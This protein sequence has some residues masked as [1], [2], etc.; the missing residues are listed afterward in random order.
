VLALQEG[1]GQSTDKPHAHV[2][3]IASGSARETKG[4]LRRAL[5]YHFINQDEY[6]KYWKEYD[7]IAAIWLD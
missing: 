4:D 1:S 6:D 2:A 5:G 7:E 3:L